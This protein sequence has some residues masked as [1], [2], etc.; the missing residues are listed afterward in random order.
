[1]ETF[2]HKQCILRPGRVRGSAWRSAASVDGNQR[3]LHAGTIGGYSSPSSA[4]IKLIGWLLLVPQANQRRM[5]VDVCEHRSEAPYKHPHLSLGAVQYILSF[6][7]S[8]QN[9]FFKS[10]RPWISLSCQ[11]TETPWAC[12]LLLIVRSSRQ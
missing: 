10:P 6:Q 5:D 4:H 11:Q 9:Y 8:Q 2:I 12:S 7:F 1:M 3:R